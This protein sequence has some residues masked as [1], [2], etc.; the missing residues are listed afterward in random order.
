[1]NITI[2]LFLLIAN[3]WFGFQFINNHPYIS[4]FNFFAAGCV[5]IDIWNA[6][7]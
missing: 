6:L 2:S 4:A 5:F 1:M 7:Q 3:L